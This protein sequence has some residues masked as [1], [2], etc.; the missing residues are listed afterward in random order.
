M[1]LKQKRNK[2]GKSMIGNPTLFFENIIKNRKIFKKIK[3]LHKKLFF[4]HKT[5]EKSV[6]TVYNKV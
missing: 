4:Q 3:Y 1:N 6:K 5:I 2:V